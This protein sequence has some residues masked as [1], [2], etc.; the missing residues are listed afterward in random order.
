MYSRHAR[1]ELPPSARMQASRCQLASPQGHLHA[2]QGLHHQAAGTCWASPPL[3]AICMATMRRVVRCRNASTK[4]A[5]CSTASATAHSP[6]MRTAA[7]RCC[8]QE[9]GVCK[10]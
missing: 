3:K 9:I 8:S 4:P 7:L 10:T 5:S 2:R 6:A 1:P